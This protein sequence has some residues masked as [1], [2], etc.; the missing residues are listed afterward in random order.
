MFPIKCVRFAHRIDPCRTMPPRR[1]PAAAAPLNRHDA[2]ARARAGIA[3]RIKTVK[4]DLTAFN[5]PEHVLE[6]LS[7]PSSSQVMLGRYLRIALQASSDHT[8]NASDGSHF[9]TYIQTL[10]GMTGKHSTSSD[11]TS[12][13]ADANIDPRTTARIRMA[14]AESC[15]LVDR[16][17]RALVDQAVVESSF[18][19]T[20]SIGH[21]HVGRN[22]HGGK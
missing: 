2:M 5:V 16:D 7:S 11:K 12:E 1:R 13:A 8:S 14:L 9:R 20:A 10:L 22:A 3:P 18:G 4:F 21:R 19:K 17:I 6:D 15:L